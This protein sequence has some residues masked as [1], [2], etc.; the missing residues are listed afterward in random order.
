MDWANERYVRVYTRETDDDLMLALANK[1]MV[2]TVKVWEMEGRD[3]PMSG[4]WIC[5]VSPKSK[6][7]HV[8]DAP[9]PARGDSRKP[10]DDLD[11]DE[12]PF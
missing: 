7:V 10:A 1:P 6:A 11:D 9:V 12:I 5:A 4:N 2:I 8:T 3:G